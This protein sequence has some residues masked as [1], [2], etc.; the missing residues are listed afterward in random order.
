MSNVPNFIY[1]LPSWPR[2]SWDHVRLSELLSKAKVEQARMLGRMEALG[3][4]LRR[5]AA[6]KAMTV[7][8][9]KSSEIEG[10]ILNPDQV[11]SSVARHLGI[12]LDNAV[13]VD[14][15]V[16]GVVM[17]MMDATEKYAQP[18]TANRL[19]GWHNVL[20]PTGMSDMRKIKV[21]GYRESPMEVVSGAE[22]HYRIHFEA[23]EASKLESEMNTFLKWFNDDARNKEDWMVISGVAHLWFVT[24]HPFDDGNG[25]IA[26]AISDMCLARDEKS[27][28]RFYSLSSQIRK[29]SKEYYH[30]LE[31]TQRGG[32]DITP[33][34]DWFVHCTMRAIEG[35]QKALA[36]VF[37][38]A[39][40]WNRFARAEINERQREMLNRLL[41][42]FEGK[43]TP[44]KWSKITK[45]AI[46]TAKRDI[47]NLV[48]KEILVKNP[49]GGRSTN[50]R[51]AHA[52][53]NPLENAQL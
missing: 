7:E 38:K 22:G 18:L 52:A 47:Q 44:E 4:D 6:L 49:E 46:R 16:E 17:M 21:A 39:A 3:F 12:H 27:P 48:E 33:W 43:L 37:A 31:S 34:M 26:R 28:Q 35:S 19:F 11:R 53:H 41:D 13:K 15:N 1:Q 45:V 20:F 5:D 14:K 30:V 42:G 10:E 40:F 23:P 32:T 2:F 50:Y 36:D 24:I 8:V 9:I 29:E 25:R 51:L